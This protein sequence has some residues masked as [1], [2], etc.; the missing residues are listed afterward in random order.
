M[1]RHSVFFKRQGILQVLPKERQE[2][3]HKKVHP[4]EAVM[5]KPACINCNSKPYACE[6]D[7]CPAKPLPNKREIIIFDLEGFIEAAFLCEAATIIN[8]EDTNA[9]Q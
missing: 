7:L 9:D 3:P 6:T 2:E 1:R 5:N 8:Q 4:M